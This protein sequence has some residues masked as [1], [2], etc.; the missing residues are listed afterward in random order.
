LCRRE[1]TDDGG[2]RVQA[3]LEHPGDGLV[4]R[5]PH[6][7]EVGLLLG[8]LVALRHGHLDELTGEVDDD[9]LARA[10]RARAEGYEVLPLAC[11]EVRLF[12]ELAASRL[13]GVLADDV[14]Q[15]GRRFPQEAAHGVA[16]LLEQQHPVLRVER[17]HRDG[18]GVGNELTAHRRVAEIDV[19]RDDVPHPAR[20]D[21]LASQDGAGRE[22]V[23][24]DQP[25]AAASSVGLVPSAASAVAA[26][27]SSCRVRAAA[28]SPAKSGCGRVGRDLNSGWACVATKYGCT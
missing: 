28:T 3:S 13:E 17:D 11:E 9:L 14:E 4:E 6:G 22:L 20:E 7:F 5:Q 25:T 21:L 15:P 16:V 24:E 27:A 10:A 8:P 19:F 1:D 26:A 23:G 18:T 12:Y 2:R